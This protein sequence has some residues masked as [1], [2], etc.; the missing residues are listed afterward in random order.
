MASSLED[1][2]KGIEDEYCRGKEP[3]ALAK[4]RQPLREQER[5][6]PAQATLMRCPK[7]G[8]TREYLAF[9]EI[10]VERCTGCRGV[11]RDP[12]RA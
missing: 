2:K 5:E 11:W 8:V 9:Q 1:R 7:C 10:Q 6:Q 4:T 3:E 12:W